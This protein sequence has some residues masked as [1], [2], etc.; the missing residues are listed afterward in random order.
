MS[1]LATVPPTGRPRQIVAAARTLLEEEGAEALTM[2]RLADRVGVKAPTLY[3]YFPDKSSVVTALAGE[4]LRETAEMLQAAE[5]EAPGSFAGLATA[6][7]AHALAHP[8]LY[9]LTMGRAVLPVGAVYAAAAPLFRAAGGDENRARAAWAFA[10]GMV[11]LELNDRFLPGADL[12]AAW[13]AG[14][15]AFAV[16]GREGAG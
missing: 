11:T 9:L 6:Y 10:H 8:H 2:R 16:R 5:H 14:I 1:D 4:M 7:R 15:A 3:K 12:A 13:E